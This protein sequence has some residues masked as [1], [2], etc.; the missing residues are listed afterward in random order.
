MRALAT[1]LLAL[2]FMLLTACTGSTAAPPLAA[3]ESV[4]RI[5]SLDQDIDCK[6]GD[7]VM[8]LPSRFG[9]AQLPLV[10]SALLCDFRFPIVYNEGGIVCVMTAERLG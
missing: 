9:N 5:D 6:P 3:P 10:A 7:L 2:L 8:F 4:C 1:V